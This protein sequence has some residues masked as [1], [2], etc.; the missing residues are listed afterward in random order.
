MLLTVFIAVLV[1]VAAL[2]EWL[3][4]ATEGLEADIRAG[5]FARGEGGVAKHV[6]CDGGVGREEGEGFVVVDEVVALEADVS[7]G[8]D[9][10][11]FPVVGLLNQPTIS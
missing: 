1:F 10:Y 11:V 6:H 2:P 8:M 9:C 4:R 3:G 5:F 7:E